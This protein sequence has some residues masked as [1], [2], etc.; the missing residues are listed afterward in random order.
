LSFV[1]S[2]AMRGCG[3]FW[4]ALLVGVGAA[5]AQDTPFSM[6]PG[7]FSNAM[8]IPPMMERLE[9]SHRT[10][11]GQSTQESLKGRRSRNDLQQGEFDPNGLSKGRSTNAA[12]STSSMVGG[13]TKG[14]FAAKL[15][16][17]YSPATRAEAERVFREL[18]EKFPQLMRQL[19]VPPNDIASAVSAFVAGSYMAYRDVD[20]PDEHFKPLVN[21]VRQI[22]DSNP[23][24]AKAS[25]GER[26][27]LYEQMAILGTFMATT[28]MALKERPNPQTA[29]NMRK[30]AKGYLEEF[31]KTDADRVQ[32]TAQGLVLR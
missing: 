12:G 19:G 2:K 10:I 20:F 6:N 17:N 14:T 7:A 23:D 11:F 24:F 15:A 8:S 29:A 5:H 27:E 26:Q 13:G 21:Q 31:L 18:L 4:I 16:Q 1:E 28:Q 22:I 25:A 9:K 32:I 3:S 30:A